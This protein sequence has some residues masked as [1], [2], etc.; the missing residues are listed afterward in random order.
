VDAHVFVDNSNIFKGAR[1]AS[2]AF[3]PEVDRV[4][5]RLYYRNF[6]EQIERGYRPQTR[7]LAGSVPPGNDD[8]W[9]YI[10]WF[11]SRTR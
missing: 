7:V 9:Q 8:L 3:E 4:A 5:V 6:F 11:D 10:D 2:Q 1:R